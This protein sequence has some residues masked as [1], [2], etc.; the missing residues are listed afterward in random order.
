MMR[1]LPLGIL[2]VCSLVLLSKNF[3]VV[4]EMVGVKGVRKRERIWQQNFKTWEEK[5]QDR[6]RK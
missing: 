4:I 5:E 6:L 3:V 2:K 1:A